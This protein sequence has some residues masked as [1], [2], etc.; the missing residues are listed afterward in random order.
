MNSLIKILGVGVFFV[1]GLGA[2]ETNPTVP[3][4]GKP[5]QQ[6]LQFVDLQGFDT[7]LSQV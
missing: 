2:C 7:N 5:A 1:A 6:D 4:A 3:D